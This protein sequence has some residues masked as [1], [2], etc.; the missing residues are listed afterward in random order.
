[1]THRLAILCLVTIALSP[2]LR[3]AAAAAE[4]P[5]Q[6]KPPNV[7]LILTDDQD[8]RSLAYMPRVKAQ[9][10]DR[11]TTFDNG[12]V[13]DP[14]C[15]PSRA[16]ILRG[17]YVHNH[18][19]RGNTA[20]DAHDKFRDLGLEDSTIAMWLHEGGYRTALIGKY[21]LQGLEGENPATWEAYPT[22]RGFDYFFGYVR[23]RDGHNHYPAHD[24]PERPP[25][26]LYD[27]EE[28]ISS[29][30]G[31]C[32]TTDLFT[33]RAKKYIVDHSKENP[34]Q[35]F[36]LFLAHD[37][38]HAG[39][40]VASAPYPEGTGLNG[41]IQWIG[42]PGNYINTSGGEVDSYI[43]PDYAGQD[44]PESQKRFASMVRRIDNT[45]A[46][47]LQLLKDLDM[48]GETMV[49]F[50][51]DNGPHHESY[52]YGDYTPTLFESY[53]EMDG[54]KRDT[55]EGGVRV[56][57]L[58][59]WPGTIREG[60]VNDTPT[61]FHDWLAT[62]A[63]AAGVPAPANTD[64]VSMLSLLKG[65]PEPFGGKVYIEYFEGRATPSYDSFHASHKGQR[66]GEMQVVYVDGYK[67]VRYNIQSHGD[68]FKIYDTRLDPGETT[69]L[70]GSTGYFEGL[71]EKMKR[72]VLQWRRPNTTAVRPY[73]EEPIPA[74]IPEAKLSPGLSYR[75]FDLQTPWV[76]HPK[77]ISL[78]PVTVGVS[79]GL[80]LGTD[81]MT[82]DGVVVYEGYLKV[83]H[84]GI[85]RFELSTDGAAVM[86]MHEALL[87]DRDRINQTKK[88]TADMVLEEGYHPFRLVYKGEKNGKPGLELNWSGPGF[89]TQAIRAEYFYR[90]GLER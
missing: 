63:D 29:R 86:H 32:Y 70:A 22:K 73:D 51:S 71:Q 23:H 88:L 79:E 18:T 64:G 52:G 66:R 6:G 40:Q 81:G 27:G 9:L 90:L 38:P 37:T 80:D 46:D 55:W 16:S 56:P 62:F 36:F 35:P 41:G 34:D 57:T 25:V 20:P 19:I 24:A 48:D 13:T 76:P 45:V 58:V 84:T 31:G 1:M 67:G 72:R 44:W 7:V 5:P 14:L 4:T 10:I 28:E 3:A 61:A 75:Q 65:D 21:G 89:E 42:E 54:T 26:E 60:S 87:F 15:C 12:F 8:S 2:S 68:D 85:Y 77:T 50:T 59:R 11:G 83:D 69:D 82:N 39:L 33:A 43:H 49:V 74:D 30:L 78:T 47:L 17:Q 53:G